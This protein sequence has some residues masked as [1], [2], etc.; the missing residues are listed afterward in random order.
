[1]TTVNLLD[2]AT[3]NGLTLAQD[4]PEE[5]YWDGA[6][7]GFG[8][9]LHWSSKGRLL[10]CWLVQYRHE[11]KQRKR[12]IGDALLSPEKA[13]QRAMKYLTAVAEGND[14]AA[15][16]DAQRSVLTFTQAVTQYLDLKKH[17]VRASSLR[18]STLYLT[19]EKYFGALH[20]KPMNRITRSDISAA[21]DKI[22]ATGKIVTA[23]QAKTHLSAFMTWAMQR[24][25]LD[26]NPIIGSANPAPVERPDR[27]F[28]NGELAAIWSACG[29]DEYGKIVRLL[30]LTGCRRGEIGGLRW[31]EID[32]DAG[33]MTI[34]GER[35]KNHRP[36]TLPLTPMMVEIINSVPHRAARDPLFGE[37]ADGFTSFDNRSLDDGIAEPWTLHVLR[38]SVVTG[39]AEL[40][41]EPHI[42]EAV[43]NHASGHK[44]GIAG[45]YNH[46]T[47]APHIKR[48][49]GIWSDHIASIVDGSARKVVGFRKTA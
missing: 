31:S 28:K 21:I 20:R 8:L 37:R 7:K 10:K 46:A 49:L 15:E 32:F 39:M 2:R 4:R 41:I 45:R 13:R 6:L 23:K 27:A 17:E 29:D 25:H 18:F 36:L 14:P 42:I 3:V 16:K 11:G 9:R 38:H 40:G 48:A 22:T 43:V 1:M 34:P 5:L 12:K 44:G 33:T 35:T 47:Y 19:N 26:Q 24:G 30:M